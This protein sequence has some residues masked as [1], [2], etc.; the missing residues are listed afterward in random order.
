MQ[1]KLQTNWSPLEGIG[2]Y[3]GRAQG[4]ATQPQRTLPDLRGC[5]GTEPSGFQDRCLKPGSA[6]PPWDREI[7][8]HSR[9][10][11]A[12]HVA[13]AYQLAKGFQ[14][15]HACARVGGS[16]A[17]PLLTPTVWGPAVPIERIVGLSD[18]PAALE[19]WIMRQCSLTLPCGVESRRPAAPGRWVAQ[20]GTAGEPQIP[21]PPCRRRG[22]SDP[23][24]RQIVETPR[25][26]C[27]IRLRNHREAAEGLS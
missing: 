17:D 7:S 16:S 27:T 12:A 8:E 15:A 25:V 10:F 13:S 18:D 3:E 4:R 20:I 24:T 2:R 21:D 5:G 14:T 26:G 19:N 9:A 6:T 23:H 11:A 1:T 22:K